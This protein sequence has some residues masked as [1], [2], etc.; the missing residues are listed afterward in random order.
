MDIF[1]AFVIHFQILG[2]FVLLRQSCY[3]ARASLILSACS[4]SVS[5]FSRA[6]S[7]NLCQYDQFWFCLFNFETE[8]PYIALVEM[9]SWTRLL[10]TLWSAAS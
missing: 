5:T 3:V 6:G 8:P 1:L 9:H 7:I 2:L 10:P 4:I